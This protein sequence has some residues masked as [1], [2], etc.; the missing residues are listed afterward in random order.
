M[1]T[2]KDIV[3]YNS[4]GDYNLVYLGL[5]SVSDF[6]VTKVGYNFVILSW[7]QAPGATQY[8]IQMKTNDT[9]VTI[10]QGL[11]LTFY[12]V[13]GLSPQTNYTFRIFAGDL[14]GFSNAEELVDTATIHQDLSMCDGLTCGGNE[15]DIVV[16]GG[17]CVCI[18]NNICPGNSYLDS[19]DCSCST[20][21]DTA[22][23]PVAEGGICD[24]GDPCT[25]NDVCVNHACQSGSQMQCPADSCTQSYCNSTSGSCVNTTI[26]NCVVTT[27]GVTTES[28]P[29]LAPSSSNSSIS[30]GATAGIVIGVLFVVAVAV[31]IFLASR[32]KD[33]KVWQAHKIIAAKLGYRNDDDDAGGN[34]HL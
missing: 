34:R 24:D 26:P 15:N 10:V 31:L 1:L 27:T 6:N 33:S 28:S 32:P 13:N 18:C 9:W 19:T 23:N 20:C 8:M 2:R 29:V 17:S 30:A 5:G 12:T 7:N 22:G 21:F 4:T 11:T 16:V 3:D 25:V 14:A